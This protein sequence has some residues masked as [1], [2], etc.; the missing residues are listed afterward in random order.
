MI[1]KEIIPHVSFVSFCP[2]V[3]NLFCATGAALF[4]YYEIENQIINK[5]F[6]HFRAE[7]YIFTCHCWLDINSILV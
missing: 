7:F 2:Y 5:K 1:K 6:V 4:Q 3:E